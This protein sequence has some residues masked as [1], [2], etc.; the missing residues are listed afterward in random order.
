MENISG[1]KGNLSLRGVVWNLMHVP[2]SNVRIPRDDTQISLSGTVFCVL[3][4]FIFLKKSSH[5]EILG[6]WE[7]LN[8]SGFMSSP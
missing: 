3:L 1:N 2:D 8:H 5:S 7:F 4:S 6:P